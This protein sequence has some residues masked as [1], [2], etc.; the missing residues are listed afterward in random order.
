[1]L[2]NYYN[3][4]Q[5]GQNYEKVL[6]RA[7]KGLQS[8]ELNEIQSQGYAQTQGIADAILKEGDLIEDGQVIVKS[9]VQSGDQPEVGNAFI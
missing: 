3:R 9:S 1:M 4:H 7:G 2:A 5:G 6:F 8:A